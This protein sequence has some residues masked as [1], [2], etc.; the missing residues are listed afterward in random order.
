[1][2]FNKY[3]MTSNPREFSKNHLKLPDAS[4]LILECCQFARGFKQL[5]KTLIKFSVLPDA[6]KTCSRNAKYAVKK[7]RIL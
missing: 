6:S 1:M 2:T 7:L 4:R 5:Y 3:M